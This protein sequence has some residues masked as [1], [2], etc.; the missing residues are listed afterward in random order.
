M[1]YGVIYADPPW[2]WQARSPKGEDRSAKNHY[3][4]MS[5][6]DIKALHPQIDIWAADDCVLFLWAINSMLPQALEVIDAWGFTFKTVGFTWVKTNK[7]GAPFTG[8]GYWTRQNTESCL[9]ATRGKPQ[10]LAKK[11]PQVLLAPRGEHSA[12]PAEIHAR[13]KLLVPGPYMEMFA[14][15]RAWGWDAWGNEI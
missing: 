4:V 10:R 1:S 2:F 6:A 11:I 5:L 3:P 8:M 15:K 7:N 12:K 14:R 9:L 13:I